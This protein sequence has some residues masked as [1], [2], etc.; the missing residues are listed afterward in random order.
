MIWGQQVLPPEIHLD[1][2]IA[3]DGESEIVFRSS[4]FR[5]LKEE[6]RFEVVVMLAAFFFCA[7]EEPEEVE[8]VDFPGQSVCFGHL[9]HKQKLN[10]LLCE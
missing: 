1:G 8:G 3:L 6:E 2:D 7:P 4:G 5:Y 10:N 9:K